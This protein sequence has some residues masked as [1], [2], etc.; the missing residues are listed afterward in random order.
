[1]NKK[2]P[3]K[4][5]LGCFLKKIHGFVNVDV[6]EDVF[7][8]V[9]DN[10]FSLTKFENDSVNLIYTCH[11]LEHLNYKD[12]ITALKRWYDLLEPGGTLR[13]AVPD[14]EAVM[15]YYLHNK[16]LDT[17]KSFLWGSQK[18]EYDFHYNGWDEKTM[19][20]ALTDAGFK[21]AKR[22]DW[23]DTEHFFVDDYSM[24]ALP[25]IAYKS[26]RKNDTIE[27]KQMSLN[28]EATK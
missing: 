20:K 3:L 17:L 5:H 25:K 19:F 12:S 1:M 18:H 16:D 15:E 2:T 28:V 9:V 26:R 13:I 7:P 10:C 8:D 23:R 27:G 22:Y 11:T 24:S 6:R 21:N 4:L 14:I